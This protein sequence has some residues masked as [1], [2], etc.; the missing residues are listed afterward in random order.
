MAGSN[1]AAQRGI[2]IRDG[3][4]LEKAGTVTAVMFDKTGTLTVGKPEVVKIW[5][6][7]AVANPNAASVAV[8]LAAGLA[9]HSSHPI[10]QTIAKLSAQVVEV[11]DWKEV[12]GA[13]VQGSVRGPLA[14]ISSA[15][16]GLAR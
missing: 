10:S 2:L 1:A 14:G 9:A 6:Q 4:A 5:E 11:A 15:E 16:S 3:V 7:G 8:K 12:H 13:G